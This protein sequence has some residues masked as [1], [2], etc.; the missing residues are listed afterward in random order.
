MHIILGDTA[1]GVVEGVG[2]A[3]NS[4]LLERPSPCEPDTVNVWTRAA[5][6]V[7]AFSPPLHH[8][9]IAQSNLTA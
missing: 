8:V 5:P 3:S 6:L 4:Y 2:P 7:R 1:L 9:Y